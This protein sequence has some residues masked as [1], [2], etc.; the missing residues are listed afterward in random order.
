MSLARMKHYSEAIS[1]YE[2]IIQNHTNPVTRLTATW[3]RAA[4]ILLMNGSGGSESSEN[5]SELTSDNLETLFDRNPAHKIAFD[6]YKSEKDRSIKENNLNDAGVSENKNQNI[7]KK[8]GYEKSKLAEVESRISLFNPSNRPELSNRI[9][10]DLKLLLGLNRS[11]NS[12]NSSI[13]LEFRL[14]QNY[15]N[16]FNPVTTIKYDLPK[17][18]NVKIKIYDLLGREV[19]ILI[20]NDLKKAGSYQIEWNAGNFASGVYFYRIEAGNFVQSKKMVLVK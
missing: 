19:A 15:P 7:D 14:H 18:A 6:T 10:E 5:I 16:P 9:Q 13:P 1:G 3:D 11:N 8:T 4:A 20:N 2:N 17:D 12:N